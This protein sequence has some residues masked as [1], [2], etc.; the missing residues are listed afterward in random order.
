MESEQL[1]GW[2][3][4]AARGEGQGGPDYAIAR[5]YLLGEEGLEKNEA[6]AL[7]WLKQAVERGSGSAQACLGAIH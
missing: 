5:A 4:R 7:S 6:T 3:G 2:R 1:K